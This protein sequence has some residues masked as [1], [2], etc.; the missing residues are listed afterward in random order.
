MIAVEAVS[1][2]SATPAAERQAMALGSM[3]RA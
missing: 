1:A 2:G 3:M